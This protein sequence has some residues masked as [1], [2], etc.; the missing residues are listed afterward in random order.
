MLG[1]SSKKLFPF[2]QGP[3]TARAI[4]STGAK[5]LLEY[6]AKDRRFSYCIHSSVYERKSHSI[7]NYMN[8]CDV[9]LAYYIFF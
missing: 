5:G 1:Y 2:K 6:V 8:T 4:E 7:R 9:V 3:R